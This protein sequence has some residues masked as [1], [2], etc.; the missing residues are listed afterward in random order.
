MENQKSGTAQGFGVAGLV[1]GILTF[2]TAF[3]PCFGVLVLYSGGLAIAICSL[4]YMLTYGQK[5][6]KGLLIAAFIL[7]IIGFCVAWLQFEVIDSALS[8]L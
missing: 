7:S 4:G 1:V 8:G 2:I 5:V 6:P 3:I